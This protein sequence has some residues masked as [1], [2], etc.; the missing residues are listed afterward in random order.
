MYPSVK[1]HLQ[2]QQL[3]SRLHSALTDCSLLLQLDRLTDDVYEDFLQVVAKGRNIPLIDVRKVAKGRVWTGRQAQQV[4]TGDVHDLACDIP[5]AIG[6]AVH[7]E[8]VA[9]VCLIIAMAV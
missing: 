2:R 9:T 5:S 6:C 3:D 7:L 1:H 8:S 4:C